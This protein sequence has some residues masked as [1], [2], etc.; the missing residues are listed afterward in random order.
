LLSLV[1]TMVT[2][3]LCRIRYRKCMGHHDY[4]RSLNAKPYW[5]FC[6]DTAHCF[7]CVFQALYNQ[8]HSSN[9]PK[10][11]SVNQYHKF[12][13]DYRSNRLFH[14]RLF[15]WFSQKRKGLSIFYS[16]YGQAFYM[17]CWMDFDGYRLLILSFFRRKNQ[18]KLWIKQ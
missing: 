4:D 7:S 8:I 12:L 17:Y 15:M 3:F 2:D 9:Q 14:C 13:S 1:W 16:Q 6:M 18:R 10:G 5:F 11:I